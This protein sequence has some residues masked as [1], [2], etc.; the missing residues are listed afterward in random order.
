MEEVAESRDASLDILLGMLPKEV[1]ANLAMQSEVAHHKTIVMDAI[2]RKD[3]KSVEEAIESLGR[4][5]T[6]IAMW[7]QD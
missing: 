4:N 1:L 7:L 3:W 5:V 2:E 6:S